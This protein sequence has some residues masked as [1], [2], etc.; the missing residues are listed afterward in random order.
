MRLNQNAEIS[1]EKLTKYLLAPEKRNDKS[2][3]LAQAGYVR[4]NWSILKDHLRRKVLPKNARLVEDT[5]Y[6]KMVEIRANLKGPNGQVLPVR[7]IW[8][9]DQATGTAK[10][11]T[12]YP[13]RK[14]ADRDEL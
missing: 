1:N 9:A 14:K 12:M 5:E 3:W 10:F 8:M 13:D 4:E 6:G 11:I 2:K 7:T